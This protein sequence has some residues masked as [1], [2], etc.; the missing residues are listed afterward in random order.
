MQAVRTALDYAEAELG[1]RRLLLS[2]EL[3]TSGGELLLDKYGELLSLSRAGQLAMRLVLE[4]YLE[5]VERDQED[6]PVRL[7]PFTGRD[8]ISGP[9]TI[10][11]DP[12]ISFGRPV[13]VRG[14]IKTA[15]LAERVDSGE[16]IEELARDYELPRS[17]IEAAILYERA[18]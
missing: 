6:F 4:A 10:L 9:K 16:S 1:I 8:V 7:Y 12:Q 3:H 18:A 13:L 5:R 17:E 11:I 15:V 2:P 14:C